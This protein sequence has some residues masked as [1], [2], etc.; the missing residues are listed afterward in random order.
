MAAVDVAAA[1]ARI[2]VGPPVNGVV[3]VAGPDQFLLDELIR[4]R[5]K[6]SGDPR[7]VI[8]DPRASYYGIQPGMRTLLPGDGAGIAETHLT[9]WAAQAAS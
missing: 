1:V 2:A 4:G 9:D 7:E 8:A 6:A 5:L 3:E